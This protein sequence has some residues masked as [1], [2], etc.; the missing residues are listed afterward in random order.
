[1]ANLK[2]FNANE[3]KPNEGFTPMPAGEYVAAIVDSEMKTT[4]AG[5][6]E[7][8]KLTVQILEGPHEGRRLWENLNLSN[9]NADAV[10]IARGTL[11]AICRA[12]N[13]MEPNDSLDLHD[14][15]FLVKVGVKKNNQ[16]GEMENRI[17]AYNAKSGT[18]TPAANGSKKPWQK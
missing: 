15:P 4:K 10:R 16:T 14:I 1:M 5:D 13:V 9:P 6:G 7:Y 17:S 2:G 8:L 12:V 11:S 18:N 3:V